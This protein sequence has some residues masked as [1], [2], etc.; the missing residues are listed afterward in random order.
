MSLLLVTTSF[1]VNKKADFEITPEEILSH[2]S[3][4]AS[5]DLKGRKPGTAENKLAASYIRDQ[6]K[7][8]GL[9]LMGD[10]GFQYVDLVVG[11]E[12]GQDN[13]LII[14][15]INY[16]A[17]EDFIPISF[18][19]S[20][21]LSAEVVFVGYGF[22]I[23][24][25][26]I[27]WN[28]YEA[29]DVQDKWV[30]ILTGHPVLTKRENP[31]EDYIAPRFKVLTA[32]DYGAKG[33]L[34]VDPD[35]KK[36]LTALAYDKV[37]S[38]AGIP[39]IQIHQKLANAILKKQQADIDT[40]V[41]TI[42]QC[43]CPV[44][45]A[46]DEKVYA[47]TDVN[48]KLIRSQNVVAMVEAPKSAHQNEFIV[49]GAHYDH[50]GMGG[51]GSGSR[52][53][54]TVVI[55]NGADDNASG[56]A[57][58]IEL[59]G[60]FQKNKKMLNRSVVFVA[61]TA[62]EM[63]LLGSS[64]F[65]QSD[66]MKRSDVKAM[67]NFDMIGRL[68]RDERSLLVGGSGT[69]VESENLLKQHAEKHR[70]T[71]KLSPEG[72][73]PSDHAVFYSKNIPVFFISTGAH[74]DYHTWKDDVEFIDPEGEKE[75]LDFA[76]DL[77]QEL[78]Q[79]GTV[80]TFKEAGPKERRSGHGYKITLGFMPDFAGGNIDGL[81]VEAIS[82]GGPAEKAGML[83]GDIIQAINGM[84]IGNIYD[85]M[86]RLKNLQSG[87]TITVDVLRNDKTVVLLVQL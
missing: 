54:D 43:Q 5:D 64:K 65:V 84:K 30:M 47:K 38:T 48:K 49:V 55:H 83:N 80:L 52:N 36:S 23:G 58:I 14:N 73:G 50:L 45:F 7:Q 40:I 15:G 53:P 6:F 46:S 28:D 71:L 20:D 44:S 62:E 86:N 57:G 34:F 56:V 42:N 32:K 11:V 13:K 85:Y 31:F 27:S 4:L 16:K 2:I 82:K 22:D 77:I 68:N 78:T 35:P 12:L 66:W 3:Y 10:N 79:K 18:T 33:V 63:G 26:N 87:D 74:A 19:E 1:S 75:V 67:V 37:E 17:E 59:A 9:R 61:F 51:P 70:F 76:Y 39:V 72:Y 41:K 69:A 81:R 21:E 8:Y 60:K 25:N 24:K 29:V